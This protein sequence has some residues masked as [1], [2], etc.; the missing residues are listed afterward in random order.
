MKPQTVGSH[1]VI[2]GTKITKNKRK[3]K[4]TKYGNIATA[5]RSNVALA[6]A[7]AVM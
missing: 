5:T 3:N 2:G 6:T 7:A 4:A 1:M